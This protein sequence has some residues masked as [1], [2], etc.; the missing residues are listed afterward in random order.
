MFSLPV[1][2]YR[3]SYCTTPSV[4]IGGGGSMDKMLKFYVKFFKVMG[5]LMGKVLSG[6]YPV[7]GQVLLASVYKG[8]RTC[9]CQP[10]GGFGITLKFYNKFVL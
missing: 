9:C 10:V 2:M 4:G 3:K 8:T 6:D 7:H 5:K 1:L